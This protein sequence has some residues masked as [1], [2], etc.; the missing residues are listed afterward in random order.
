[1]TPDPPGALTT[2]PLGADAW[3]VTPPSP[4]VP[5]GA[6]IAAGAS[7]R[8]VPG[9][10]DRSAFRDA[11][12]RELT[13][14]GSRPAVLV[15]H[16]ED[17]WRV[18]GTYGRAAGSAMLAEVARRL[19]RAVRESDEVGRWGG[20]ELAVM[21]VDVADEASAMQVAE[22]LRLALSGP[23]IAD[24]RDL[25]TTGVSIG[26]ALA[27]RGSRAAEAVLR[28][29]ERALEHAELDGGG[30][31]RA[32]WTLAP[33]DPPI[34]GLAEERA[35]AVLA[36][37]ARGDSGR[38]ARARETADLTGRL[39]MRAGLD[40]ATASRA[41]IA[42]LAHDVGAPGA[43]NRFGWT[44]HDE[45]ERAA[46]ADQAREAARA[47]RSDPDLREVAEIALHQNE[48]F[49]GRGVPDGLS[50][51][52]I[53]AEARALACVVA[54]LEAR[55]GSTHARDA[56]SRVEQLAGDA[57]DPAFLTAL[58]EL[59]EAQDAVRREPA[60]PRTGDHAPS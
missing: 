52:R 39:V 5:L 56:L 43:V 33:A 18:D 45:I 42:A 32:A 23:V 49:D 10:L 44:S 30:L 6:L 3:D 12:R 35:L 40:P 38:I 34:D 26:V 37:A 36:R 2:T 19:R 8:A 20:A 16:V 41:R 31:I 53:P 51:E 1:M 22:K 13:R 11:V 48:R 25:G 28:E 15:L 50:G 46:L 57:L 60:R 14:R 59:I 54:F 58:A 24:G 7:A 47:L 17:L 27:R 9:P 21:A 55:D 29:A 4:S